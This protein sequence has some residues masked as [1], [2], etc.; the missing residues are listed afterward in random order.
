MRC[1]YFFFFLYV[2]SVSHRKIKQVKSAALFG[3][4]FFPNEHLKLYW[5]IF[6]L[7]RERT[8]H[9]KKNICMI[10]ME[11]RKTTHWKMNA[12]VQQSCARKTEIYFLVRGNERASNLEREKMLRMNAELQQRWNRPF[13]S[14]SLLRKEAFVIFSMNIEIFSYTF[15]D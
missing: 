10:A 6:I 12:P 2:H 8:G 11:L 7:S 1:K 9:D 3:S 13:S 15:T 5:S 4:Y 14:D